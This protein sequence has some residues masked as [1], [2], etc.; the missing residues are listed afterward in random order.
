MS[1]MKSNDLLLIRALA[2]NLLALEHYEYLAYEKRQDLTSQN[3]GVIE[4]LQKMISELRTDMSRQQAD[5]KISR[6]IRKGDDR[7]D[8]IQK[9]ATLTE[10][11]NQFY[12][13]KMAFIIC[14]ECDMLLAIIWVQYPEEDNK[15]TFRCHRRKGGKE[16]GILC[17]NKFTEEV[18]P[19]SRY[20]LV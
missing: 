14:P 20:L 17:N 5:L 19:D 6:K 8:V 15:L 7:E 1:D 10:R 11:A 4:K 9:I 18:F 13:Q 16:P 2:Q 3:I 12:K